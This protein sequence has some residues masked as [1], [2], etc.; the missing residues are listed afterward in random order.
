MAKKS[1]SGLKCNCNV[2]MWIVECIV[3]A[4]G[5]F[6]LVSGFVTHLI[7]GTAAWDSANM[8]WI[9]GEYFAGILII[10]IGKML[11]WNAHGSCKL[12]GKSA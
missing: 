1:G 11:A 6:V 9:L 8:I 4:F 10:G 7:A 12:H 5:L 3:I 2:P